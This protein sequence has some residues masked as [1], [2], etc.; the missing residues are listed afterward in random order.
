M[1]SNKTKH[2]P[3]TCLP[4]TAGKSADRDTAAQRYKIYCSVFKN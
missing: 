1:Y 4:D 2:S 3:H